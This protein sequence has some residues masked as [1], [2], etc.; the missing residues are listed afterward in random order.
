MRIEI[1]PGA[2]FKEVSVCNEMAGN[3]LKNDENVIQAPKDDWRE[4]AS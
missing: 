2:K 3:P 4:I 1:V